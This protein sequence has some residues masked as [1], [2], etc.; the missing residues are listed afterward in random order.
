MAKACRTYNGVTSFDGGNYQ[1]LSINTFN[2][3][4]GATLIS[5]SKHTCITGL[6]LGGRENTA[7][8]CFG[9]LT[10][11]QLTL[12]I[13]KVAA[14]PGVLKTGT[15]GDFK[16]QIMG[17]TLLTNDPL[18]VKS[19]VNYLPE[20]SQFAYHGSCVGKTSSRSDVRETLMT[21]HVTA[22]TGCEN[23]WGRPKML[24]EYEGWQKA[25]SNASHPATPVEH[26]LLMRSVTDY[27]EPLIEIV[28]KHWSHETPLS[29]HE[30]LCGRTGCKFIDAIP[31]NTAIGYPLTGPKRDFVI[32]LEPTEEKPNNRVFK[33]I[34]IE[35]IKECEDLYKQGVRNHFVAKAC[36]KDEVL[37][38]AKEK[39]RIFYA[40]P[41][42]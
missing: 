35:H 40:N 21:E 36:K 18:H 29:D 19:P 7:D 20:G 23:I 27:Q 38:L 24:P 16:P 10:Q 42:A 39:V 13:E 9:T 8:G 6:H 26:E 14:V 17:A 30:N 34:V 33:D 5:E 11:E 3:L 2:G 25:M 12:A 22:V 32:E 15:M 4:C 31:L 37:P 1:K 28:D 41:I